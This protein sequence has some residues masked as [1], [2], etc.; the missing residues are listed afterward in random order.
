MNIS[1]ILDAYLDSFPHLSGARRKNMKGAIAR[2]GEVGLP[3]DTDHWSDATF[4]RFRDECL[5]SDLSEYTIESSVGVMK[6]LLI[7]AGPRTAITPRAKGWITDPPFTGR[8]LT[9]PRRVK[10][11]WTLNALSEVY[12]VAG[13]AD[14]PVAKMPPAVFWRSILVAAYNTGLR[15]SDLLSMQWAGYN[16]RERR[17]I[18]RMKKTG[19]DMDLP[20]NAVLGAH[21]DAMPRV[22]V[23]VFPYSIATAHHL[24][25]EL[26]ELCR[27]VDVPCLG[28]HAMRRL[29]G[30]QFD[31]IE[32]GLGAMLLG[33]SHTVTSVSYVPTSIHLRPASDAI[34]Q[35]EAF[36]VGMQRILSGRWMDEMD[37]DTPSMIS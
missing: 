9:L 35:P 23:R 11:A 7:F 22:D 15:L 37:R 32:M 6:T 1:R 25:T 36:V 24:R 26:Y 18:V 27:I 30:Q 21:L 10:E 4:G 17:L 34:P 2:W 14:R 12:R 33:H 29:A 31:L 13:N 3:D 19:H 20:V 28:F 5:K 8:R 16:P